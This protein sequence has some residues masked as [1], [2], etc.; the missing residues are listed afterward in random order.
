VLKREFLTKTRIFDFE[1]LAKTLAESFVSWANAPATIP[2]RSMVE[3]AT[4]HKICIRIKQIEDRFF[5]LLCLFLVLRNL[6]KF[7]RNNLIKVNNTNYATENW[8]FI[9]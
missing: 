1:P 8:P 7:Y 5:Y 3:R 6:T 9:A 2:E 4:P